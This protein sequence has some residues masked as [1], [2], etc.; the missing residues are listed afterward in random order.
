MIK[1]IFCVFTL[2][3]LSSNIKIVYSKN[4]KLQVKKGACIKWANRHFY[5]INK[6]QCISY[7]YADCDKNDNNFQNLEACKEECVA[8]KKLKTVAN[9]SPSNSLLWVFQNSK[10]GSVPAKVPKNATK[11]SVKVTKNPTKGSVKVT[12]KPTKVPVTV[13][14]SPPKT[15]VKVTKR[16][17][18]GSVK[19]TK[20]PAKTPVKVTKNPNPITPVK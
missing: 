20:N 14:K 12:K 7:I 13:P 2:I 18:K 10:K 17:T 1:Y 11:G 15:P 5:D 8:V 19:V 9:E 16:P 3:F 6:K 4:C